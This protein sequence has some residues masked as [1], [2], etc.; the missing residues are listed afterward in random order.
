MNEIKKY[1]FEIGDILRLKHIQNKI[2]KVFKCFGWEK[3]S[4]NA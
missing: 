1:N 4:K 2:F 3:I